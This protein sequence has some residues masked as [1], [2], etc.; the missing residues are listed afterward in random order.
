VPG[1][2]Y[3]IVRACNAC[4]IS[5]ACDRRFCAADCAVDC[6]IGWIVPLDGLLFRVR[7]SVLEVMRVCVSA[8]LRV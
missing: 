5:H 8:C 2:T 4:R 6:A 3:D 1:F 7:V